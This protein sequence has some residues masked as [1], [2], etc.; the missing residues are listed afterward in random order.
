[1]ADTKHSLLRR[2]LTI[3]AEIVVGIY[4]VVDS[5]VA[6]L[7]LPFFRYL[8]ALKLVQ[9]MERAIASLPPY[10]IL[11]AMAVPFGI[12]ELTKVFAVFLM[13]EGQFRLG[14]TL[15]IGA[16]IVSIFVCERIF[17]A[18]KTQL[19]TIPWFKVL[20]DWTMA[21]K[22]HVFGWLRQTWIWK[23]AESLRQRARISLRRL[24]T[25]LRFAFGGRPR[26]VIQR[27]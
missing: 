24:R 22:D 23:A 8:S 14:M 2:I 9:R 10:V 7:F 3:P 19:L 1:M 12:A 4:V 18:G 11:V 5:L 16:Y 13:S 6:P 25:R 21:I 15:F 17:H 27:R 20:F 26:S